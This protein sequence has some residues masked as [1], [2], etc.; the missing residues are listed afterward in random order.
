MDKQS[1]FGELIY[2][3]ANKQ[4]LSIR[5]LSERVEGTTPSTFSKI[6]AGNY[7][8]LTE[9][10]LTR[11]LTAL[12]PD[13]KEAQALMV[14]AYLWDMCPTTYHT[15]INIEPPMPAAYAAKK[16]A[17]DKNPKINN[18]LPNLLNDIGKAAIANPSFFEH[19]K[20]LAK[21]SSEFTHSKS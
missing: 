6:R 11:I 9:E 10:R 4:D 13:D 3:F 7:S 2:E 1:N 21:L 5:D 17:K 15:A 19:V 18:I 12:A 14:C 16:S 20:S 8:K